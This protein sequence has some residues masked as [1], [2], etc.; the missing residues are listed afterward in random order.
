MRIVV[1]GTRG[2]PN[3]QGGIETHCEELYPRIAAMGFDVTVVRRK[4]YARDSLTEYKGVKIYDIPNLKKKSFEAIVHTF[5]AIWAAKWTIHADIVHIHAVGPA[6]L[7]PFARLLGM[8]VVFTHH[9]PDYDREKWGKTAKFI[10]RL[11][12]RMGCLFANQIIVISNVANDIIKRK[13]NRNDAHLIHNGIPKPVFVDDTQ[14]LDELGVEPRKY[15]LA[16]GRFVREKNFHA[17]V[18]AYSAIQQSEYKLVI[19]GDADIEDEY[20]RQLKTLA[21]KNGV[22]LTGFI[23]GKKLQTLL[24]HAALFVLPSSH[25]GLPLSLLEA[26]SYDLPVLISDIPAN[27]EVG[28]EPSCYFHLDE[29]IVETLVNILKIKLKEHIHP[30]YDLKPYDWDDIAKNVAEVYRICRPSVKA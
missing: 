3:I 2:I 23:K 22:V 30:Y 7:T 26:M 19:A 18:E 28:L 6:L 8:K 5:R 20:S 13:Y 17:L 9:G 14:Y 12:E 29:N 24:S 1:T 15:I 11:G 27:K 4:S 16:M 21:K 10:I 25:E